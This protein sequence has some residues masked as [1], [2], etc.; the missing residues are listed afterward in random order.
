MSALVFYATRSGNTRRV[1]EAIGEGLGTRDRV[2]IRQIGDE[3][4][5]L[6]DDVELVVV[7]GPTEAHGVT[8]PVAAFLAGL[9]HGWLSRRRAAAFDTRV[10]WPRWLSGSAAEGIRA[11]LE[12]AGARRPI[13]SESFLVSMKPEIDDDELARARAWGVELGAAHARVEPAGATPR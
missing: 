4:V 9:P 3:P 10:R 11:R 1:A 7:G 8:E 6:S 13:A 2:E 12:A 5:E